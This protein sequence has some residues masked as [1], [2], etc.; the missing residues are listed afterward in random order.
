MQGYYINSCKLTI[1]CRR[2]YYVCD[3][4]HFTTDSILYMS[5]ISAIDMKNIEK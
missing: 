1:F 4:Y 5:V 3:I 2:C